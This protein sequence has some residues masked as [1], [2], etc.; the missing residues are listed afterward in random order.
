[1]SPSMI[2]P[3]VTKAKKRRSEEHVADLFEHLGV[4]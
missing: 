3:P 2:Q 1:M 4:K